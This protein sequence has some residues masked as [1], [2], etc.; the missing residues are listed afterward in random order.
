MNQICAWS[1]GSKWGQGR[2]RWGAVGGGG[3]VRPVV[4]PVG[5]EHKTCLPAPLCDPLE[6]FPPLEDPQ[7][8][9]LLI[10]WFK[11]EVLRGT[12]VAQSLKRLTLGFSSAQA[13]TVS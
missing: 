12:W 6:A 9:L 13:L 5:T 11:E 7:G 4:A 8:W 1:A 2:T 10:S 3:G